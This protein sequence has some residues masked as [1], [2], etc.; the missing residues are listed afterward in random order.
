MSKYE[1]IISVQGGIRDFSFLHVIQTGSGA[2][3]ASYPVG[4]RGKTAEA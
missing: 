1:H 3:P 4:T 2:H